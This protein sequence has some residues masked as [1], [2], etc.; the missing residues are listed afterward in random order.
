VRKLTRI[1]CENSP[2]DLLI[3]SGKAAL[4]KRCSGMSARRRL[5]ST[6]N[7]LPS[8]QSRCRLH[9]S[10]FTG[11][12]SDMAIL[13]QLRVVS[14]LPKNRPRESI[15]TF[16]EYS[17]GIST[18]DLTGGSKLALLRRSLDLIVLQTLVAGGLLAK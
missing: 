7:P 3:L 5:H 14:G 4:P 6:G 8:H 10:P 16:P 15:M 18:G 2:Q 9:S 13:R 11:L 17:C 1:T 12:M